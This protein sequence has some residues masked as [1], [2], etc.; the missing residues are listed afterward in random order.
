MLWTGSWALLQTSR[1]VP[2]CMQGVMRDAETL[3]AE[4][5]G[6][7]DTRIFTVTFRESPTGNSAMIKTT[8]MTLQ[9]FLSTRQA[10]DVR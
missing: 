6:K 7:G 4:P 1:F 3:F 8:C 2:V 5:Q 10:F 9:L